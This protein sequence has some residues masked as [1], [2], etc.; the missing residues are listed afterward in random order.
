[1]NWLKRKFV[2]AQ[3]DIEVGSWRSD[4]ALSDAQVAASQV[5][6]HKYLDSE[7][8]VYRKCTKLLV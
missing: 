6:D 3:D 4:H 2:L 5:G 7:Q 1:L 8:Q